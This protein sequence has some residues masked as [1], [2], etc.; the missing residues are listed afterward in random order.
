MKTCCSEQPSFSSIQ[1]KIMPVMPSGLW[2]TGIHQASTGPIP[3]IETHLG[4]KDTMDRWK[5]RWGIKRDALQVQPGLYAVGNPGKEAIVL[6]TANYKPSFDAL[7]KELSGLDAWILVLDTKGVNVWCAAGKGTFGTDELARRIGAARLK[8]VVSHKNI[9]VPQLAAPGIAGHSIKAMT[10]FKVV[11]GPVRAHDI[12][13]F[14]ENNMQA[15][16]AM[17]TVRFDLWDRVA[18]VPIELVMVMK[19]FLILLGAVAV[20]KLF[21]GNLS[22]AH[23]VS[24]T[25]PLLGALLMGTVVVPVAAAVDTAPILRTEGLGLGFV[26]DPCNR[27]LP[28]LGH[29]PVPGQPPP[30]ACGF[31][32]SGLELYR[33]QHIHLPDRGEQG[34]RHVRQ[35]FG[36]PGHV[37]HPCSW[38][39][40]SYRSTD[41]SMR[42][43][44]NISTLKVDPA[45]CTGCGTCKEVCPHGVF[46]LEKKKA[47]HHG[48]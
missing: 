3:L 18:V 36:C 4:L 13:P 11:F 5:A 27:P 16:P 17:R 26:V 22:L 10:G 20:W 15:T 1:E 19:Y 41:M 23:M 2:V 45:R 25:L 43:L 29:D 33:M 47:T 40:Y 9:I 48:S 38:S 6:A 12:K 7:R 46:A 35:A 14:L 28:G 39:E 34:D 8:D 42:Y 24:T 21:T 44:K 37:R 32:L 30:A 31:S